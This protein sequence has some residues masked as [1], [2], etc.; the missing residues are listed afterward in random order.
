MLRLIRSA[1]LLVLLFWILGL[2]IALGRPE[3]G[4]FEDVVLAAVVL[5]L[6]AAATPVRRIG[7]RRAEPAPGF[8]PAG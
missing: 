8:L 5:G 6:L 1:L 2:V 7:A 3:T 4:G